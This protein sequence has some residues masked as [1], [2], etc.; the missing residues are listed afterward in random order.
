MS[1]APE[2]F[3]SLKSKSRAGLQKLSSLNL[4]SHHKANSC[5]DAR[6]GLGFRLLKE[7]LARN[8]SPECLQISRKADFFHP[9]GF[10]QNI[11][12]RNFL[13]FRL[14]R[15]SHF[16]RLFC[17]LP[18]SQKKN[19]EFWRSFYFFKILIREKNKTAPIKYKISLSIFLPFH[20]IQI[21]LYFGNQVEGACHKKN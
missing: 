19:L 17:N 2:F 15:S 20:I 11:R 6:H 14:P 10:S 5:A 4:R 12:H 21:F 3:H 16:R 18:P 1:L 8:C 7:D 9:A 13:D